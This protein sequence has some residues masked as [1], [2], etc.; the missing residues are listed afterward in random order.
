M[1]QRRK[2]LTCPE[3]THSVLT[4]GMSFAQRLQ[5]LFPARPER[6]EDLYDCSITTI[7]TSTKTSPDP[8]LRALFGQD[9][10]TH[11]ANTRKQHSILCIHMSRHIINKTN[12]RLPASRRMRNL[13]DLEKIKAAFSIPIKNGS[14]PPSDTLAIQKNLGR[15][16]IDEELKSLLRTTNIRASLGFL[17]AMRRNIGLLQAEFSKSFS[18]ALHSPET[19][20]HTHILLYALGS[21]GMVCNRLIQI[22]YEFSPSSKIP[23]DFRK[24][25]SLIGFHV[26]RTH[27]KPKHT[28]SEVLHE[29]RMR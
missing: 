7:P 18:S 6:L 13:H 1:H 14:A 25:A 15:P 29:G 19:E 9:S 20:H 8:N 27:E 17:H 12:R 26:P 10:A 5:Y 2:T 24:G 11:L 28:P 3:V 23:A 22:L 21:I 16:D 4:K